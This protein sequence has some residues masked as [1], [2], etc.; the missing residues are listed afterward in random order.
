MPIA[1]KKYPDERADRLALGLR[2][3]APVARLVLGATYQ[4]VIFL[5]AGLEL[6]YQPPR[7]LASA[8][9][10]FRRVI[11]VPVFWK[12]RRIFSAERTALIGFRICTR[13]RRFF[14][15]RAVKSGETF[16]QP[17]FFCQDFLGE[18]RADFFVKRPQLING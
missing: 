7:L 11:R 3:P 14:R 5:L 9:P 12:D 15:H 17:A 16:L 18:Y 2:R 8:S 4:K 6:G 10:G 13:N 1:A